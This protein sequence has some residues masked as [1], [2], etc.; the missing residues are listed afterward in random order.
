MEKPQKGASTIK[1]I[2]AK[3]SSLGGRVCWHVINCH[4]YLHPLRA[5]FPEYA[6][7]GSSSVQMMHPRHIFQLARQT[8]EVRDAEYCVQLSIFRLL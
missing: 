5:S 8:E 4:V 1:R 7:Y 2:L 6:A 3:S